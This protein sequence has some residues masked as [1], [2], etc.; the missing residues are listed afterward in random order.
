MASSD[1]KELYLL[2]QDG[3]PDLLADT[4]LSRTSLFE[5]IIDLKPKSVTMFLDTCYSGMSRDEEM[6]L[7]SARPI[8]IVVEDQDGVPDNF[9]I[10]MLVK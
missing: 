3:D 4:A 2:P 9:T 5:T 10:F 1:G 6:L 7:A 8:R